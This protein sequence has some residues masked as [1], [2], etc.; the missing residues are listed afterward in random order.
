MRTFVLLIAAAPGA[1]AQPVPPAE[2][3]DQQA[4]QARASA[5]DRRVEELYRQGRVAQAV[6]LAKQALALRQQLYPRRRFPDGHAALALSLNNLGSLLQARGELV[7]AE[8]LLR[9]ALTMRQALYPRERFPDGHPQLATSLNNLG[10]VLQARAELVAAEPYYRAALAMK[11][12]LYPP[13]RYP[14]GHPDAAMSLNNLG[15]LLQARGDLAAAE[16]FLRDA[17]AMRRQLYPRERYPDGH[18]DLA[19]SLNNLGALL[20][21]RGELD[22]AEPCYRAALAMHRQLYPPGRFPEGHPAVATSLNNLAF[23]LQARGQVSQAEPCC[24]EALAMARKLYPRERY[25]AGHPD[26][27]QSLSNLGFLLQARGDLAAAEPALRDALAM[28]R[29]LYP[30]ERYPAGHPHLA[31]SLSNLGSLLQARG[32]LAAAEAF[33]RAALAMR[34]ELYP[35]ARFPA[36]HPDL[37]LSRQNLGGLLR[38]QGELATAEPHLRA[39]LALRRKLYPEERFPAGHPHLAHS[40]SSLGV[41][42]D[43]RGEP[44]AAERYYRDALAMRERLYP[45]ERFPNGHADLAVSLNNLGALL[46][47]RDPAAA[48]PYCRAALAMFRRL[49]PEAHFPEGHPNLAVSLENVGNLRQARGDL[50]RAEQCYRD[51]L[52]L[53]QRQLDGLLA[54]TAEAEALNHLAQLPLTRDGYLSVTRGQPGAGAA[55]DL[56]WQGRGALARWLGRRRLAARAAADPVS[57]DLARLL[58]EKRQALAAL[59]LSRTA[60]TPEQGRH[61]R[62]L[63]DDKERLEKELARALPA[64]AELLRSARRNPDDLRQ[65]LPPGTA[66]VDLLRYVQI[67]YDPAEPGAPR[68]RRT[69]SYVAFVVGRGRAVR[70]VEL[71][72]AEPIERAV[73][74]WRAVLTG[75]VRDGPRAPPPPADRRP[76]AAPEQVLRRLVWEPL[77]R[78]LPPGT[79]TVYL[80]PDAALTQLPWAALPGDRPGTV[81]LEEYALAVVPH[82]PFLLEALAA[83]RSLPPEEAKLLAVGGVAYNEAPAARAPAEAAARA[84]GAG[85][86]VSWP[87]LPGSARE[88]DRIL[89]LAGKRLVQTRRGKEASTARLLHDLP[90]ARWAHL[91]THGFFADQG[92]RSALQLNEKDYQRSRRGERIGVGTRSPLALSGL[93]LAGANLEGKEAPADRGILTAEAIAGL[94]LDNLDLAV[95]SACDTG[96]GE[97]AGGE[98]VFGLQRAFHVAGCKNV[99]ASLWQVDDEATAALM[100]LFYH[101]LWR[102]GLPPVEALRQAQL[103]LYRHPD[104]IPTLARERGPD[105]DRVARRPAEKRAGARAPARLWAGFVLSGLGR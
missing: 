81:L 22:A 48:E 16:P 70:R 88:L 14:D 46:L 85:T 11:Q 6:P 2:P 77:A 66:F 49:Y 76:A 10:F 60:L 24:R 42:L 30:R 91:A 104:R 100:A 92:F 57:R 59:L 39:A 63:S 55:Y 103:T 78:H 47:R 35:K 71:G 29:Q 58:A 72:P 99:V 80:A 53:R 83:G 19:Q 82:G 4:Q 97:V 28:R 52:T 95:L 98:G 89:A 37:A 50:A 96:L 68:D 102:E 93:V 21:A 67:D 65:Q 43:D 41:L 20:K 54:G 38:A 31:Q 40:L 84:A 15:F 1:L 56:V 101:K 7:A 33:Y 5:L 8:A 64:F 44:A 23:L 32:E 87:T 75:G 13:E 79:R 86:K 25:P 69:Q 17:L 36:G 61:A 27:A 62:A 34:L 90:G 105:F 51:A 45:R 3:T 74:A 12:K 94:N 73:A 18:P 26:L 9:D